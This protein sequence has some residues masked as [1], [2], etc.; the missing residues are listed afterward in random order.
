MLRRTSYDLFEAIE[1]DSFNEQ[2]ARFIFLQLGKSVAV[3][4]VRA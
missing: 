4:V 3:V 2:E 1:K